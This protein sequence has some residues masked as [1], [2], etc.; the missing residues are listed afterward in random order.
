MK[1]TPHGGAHVKNRKNVIT[2]LI[3][4]F[5]EEKCCPAEKRDGSK[6]GK[7]VIPLLKSFGK[8]E[9]KQPFSTEKNH[10]AKKKTED[11][12][13]RKDQDLFSRAL[14]ALRKRQK[15]SSREGVGL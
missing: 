1:P 15:R 5:V 14:I 6:E 11:F 2:A 9:S 12:N 8:S 10:T 3:R 4:P 7:K 13:R